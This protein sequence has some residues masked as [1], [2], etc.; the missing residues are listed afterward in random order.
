MK[1]QISFDMPDLQKAIEIAKK[2]KNYCDIVEIGTILI[3]KYGVIAVEQFV[4]AL[5]GKTILADTKIIDRGASITKLYA[6]TGTKWLTVMAGT[7]NT[8]IHR[9]CSEAENHDILVMLDMIDA[10]APG[11]SALEAKNLGVDAISFHRAYDAKE[12]LLFLDDLNMIRG[13]TDLPVFL[14]ARINRD[15]I[16]KIIETKP[17]GIIVGASITE[18]KDPL[19][20][21]KFYYNLCKPKHKKQ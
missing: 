4:D 17:Q 19:E 7:S 3:H 21:A 20:E 16:N 1:L 9:V 14:S 12:S 13:N 2:V 10:E 6:N 11:Q 5:E 8:V 18:A 15:N